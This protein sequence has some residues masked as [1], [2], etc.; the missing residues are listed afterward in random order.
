MLIERE[1]KRERRKDKRSRE[2]WVCTLTWDVGEGKA[3]FQA[4]PFTCGLVGKVLR[5]LNLGRGGR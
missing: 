2:A 5:E 3:V 4:K 1:R